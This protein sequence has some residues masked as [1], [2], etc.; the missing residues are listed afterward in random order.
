MPVPP[1]STTVPFDTVDSAMNYAR[2][3]LDDCPNGLAGNLLADTQAYAQTFYNLGWR[4]FQVDLANYGD[5][6]NT[7]EVLIPSLPPVSGT[8]PATQVYLSQSV[9]FDGQ[10]IFAPP[11]VNV[12]PQDLIIPLHLKE[13]QGGTQQQFRDMVPCDNGLPLIPKTPWMKYWEWRSFGSSNGNAIWMPGANVARDLFIRYASFLLDA[14]DDV[15]AAGAW[16][17]QKIPMLRVAPIVAYYVA[18]KFDESRGGANAPSFYQK[19]KQALRDY[20]NSTTQKNRQRVNHRRRPS[21][22][23]YARQMWG[24]Y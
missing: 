23:V 11:A 15:P 18:A 10:N 19:G 7:N 6:A 17:T 24:R 22:R 2:V 20:V 12:L 1:P 3:Y 21:S 13:R 9:Y 16:Y 8:D 5:P 4:E 14:L